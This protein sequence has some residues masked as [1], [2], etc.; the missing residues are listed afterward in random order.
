MGQYGRIG[1]GGGSCDSRGGR[2]GT[3]RDE[4]LGVKRGRVQVVVQCAPGFEVDIV[5]SQQCVV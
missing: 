3:W 5:V 4:V 1:V 2:S